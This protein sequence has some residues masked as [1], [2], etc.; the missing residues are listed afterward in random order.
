MKQIVVIGFGNI[1]T[2]HRRNLKTLYPDA[3]IYGVSAS[4]RKVEGVISDCDEV[5]MDVNSLH[6]VADMVIIASPAPF[7]AQNAIPFIKAGVPVLIEKPITASMNDAL[8]ISDACKKHTQAVAVGYCLRYLP[9]AKKIKKALDNKVI[10]NLLKANISIGQYLPDWRATKNYKE[11]VSASK[12]LGGGALLELSHEIDYSRWLL[13]ELKLQHAIVRNTGALD[14]DVEDIADIT[15]TT[16]EKAVV[17]IHLDFLQ[18]IAHRKCEFVGTEG[19]LEW[20]LIENSIV[21]YNQS[22]S[23]ILYMEP[24]YDK[25]EMYIEMLRDFHRYITG[26]SHDCIQIEDAIGTVALIEQIKKMAY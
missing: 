4:G 7:H 23:Q 14:I 20:N 18:R 1:A 21:L 24:E 22:G 25:N 10:G 6:N 11:S 9:S 26:E 13:G 19:R 2:R 3:K 5:V 8:I 15:A 17:Q 12:A 16:K